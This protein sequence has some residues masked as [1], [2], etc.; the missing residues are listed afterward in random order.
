MLK[1]QWWVNDRRVSEFYYEYNE[2]SLFS[3]IPQIEHNDN[4]T[5]ERYYDLIGVRLDTFPDERIDY[6][7]ISDRDLNI[8]ETL[9]SMEPTD[10]PDYPNG[11]VRLFYKS[12]TKAQLFKKCKLCE[13]MATGLCPV[14]RKYFCGRECQVKYNGV[15]K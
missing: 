5:P 3:D 10:R 12:Y 4:I 15:N 13:N 8:S 2:N 6:V 7:D 14:S 11:R 9:E 1:V